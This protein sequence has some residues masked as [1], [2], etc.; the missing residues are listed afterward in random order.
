MFIWYKWGRTWR[1]DNIFFLLENCPGFLVS[2]KFSVLPLIFVFVNSGCKKEDIYQKALLLL[3]T[4]I[5]KI[6]IFQ[7]IVKL[8][9]WLA[10]CYTRFIYTQLIE[11]VYFLHL[12]YIHLCCICFSPFIPLYTT[13]YNKVNNSNVYNWLPLYIYL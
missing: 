12:F 13:N 5:I 3:S 7:I 11:D 9:H 8:K 4:K 6:T 2:S 10:K 1:L